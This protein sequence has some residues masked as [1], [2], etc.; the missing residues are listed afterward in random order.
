MPS[1]R[2]RRRMIRGIWTMDKKID[3]AGLELDNCTVTESI[4]L[5]EKAAA[6]Q[7]FFSIEEINM[8]TVMLAGTDEKIREAISR[9]NHTVISEDII[10]KAANQNSL[11]REHEIADRSFFYEMMKRF[12]RNQVPV[13][14]L[15][16]TEARTL[17]E[18]EFILQKFPRMIIA[19]VEIL[20]QC[21]GELD[22]VINEINAKTQ[23]VVI[24]L[25]P[26][27]MQEQFFLDYRDKLSAGLWYGI[28][29]LA[30]GR[31]KL[32]ILSFFR[33]RKR[34]RELTA[35]VKKY[36]KQKATENEETV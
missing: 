21:T 32:R 11:Q 15:G 36:Q 22:N 9:L 6:E 20:E 27:P 1:R 18:K 17:S 23:D 16:D 29:R 7:A 3:V 31:R 14:L 5:I 10:L 34:L 4:T 13:C 8:D 28:G 24:S 12:E 30:P 25:L 2:S 35:Y 33:N 19:D 26:S